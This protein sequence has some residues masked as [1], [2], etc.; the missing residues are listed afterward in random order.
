M[1]RL[2]FVLTTVL[3]PLLCA[4]VAAQQPYT[5]EAYEYRVSKDIEY[6]VALDYAGNEARLH[7]DIYTPRNAYCNRPL[8]ILVHGGAWVGGS[9]D[10]ADIVWLA[11]SFA[12]RGYVAVTV[13][14]RLGMH[15]T[16]SYSMYALCNESISAP[17][18]YIC[19]SME[20]YRANYRAMQDVK[21]AVRFMKLRSGQDSTDA[22]NVFLIGESAGGFVALTAAFLRE[23]NERSEFCGSIADAPVPDQDLRRYGCLPAALSPV[24]PD[25]GSVAGSLHTSGADAEVQG[26]A[27][28]FGGMLDPAIIDE[29]EIQNTA[30]YLYHQ[31]SDVVVHYG[32]GRLLG[33][34]SWECFAQTNICQ[35][36]T[37]YPHAY[38][39]K[40]LMEYFGAAFPGVAHLRADITEN[41]RYLGNCFD[42]GHAIANISKQAGDIA[43]LFA[44]KIAVNG[45]VPREGC[46]LSA[47][48]GSLPLRL[49]VYPNP[50]SSHI[51]VDAPGLR[52][53]S[54][55]RIMDMLG[56]TMQDGVL[57][58][59]RSTVT[60]SSLPA[61]Q[62]HF[63]LFG[64]PGRIFRVRRE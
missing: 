5:I 9:K 15:L 34:L 17:C 58:A 20:V 32:Y 7:L 25:L 19:D 63:H 33:R 56:R 43:E 64:H 8:V 52:A 50:S 35:S 6:G 1:T 12:S 53:G 40:A 49:S 14:Y 10:D 31:G 29:K 61:G 37:H 39:S 60:V 38:G 4:I 23:E 54:T 62:Y 51:F 28:I 16:S 48:N 44:E 11:R 55:Y 26:V 2:R 27:N 45:N 36:Y 24:R 30:L 42:N 3:F 13:N 57:T 22:G 41:Y 46:T 18:A 21:G 59:E 47:D